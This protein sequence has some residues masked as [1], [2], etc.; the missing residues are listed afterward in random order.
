MFSLVD[1]NAGR[2]IL[3]EDCYNVVLGKFLDEELEDDDNDDREGPALF[4]N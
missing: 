1:N 3:A 4:S 2:K